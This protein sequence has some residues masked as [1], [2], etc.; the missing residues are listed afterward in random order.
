MT[1]ITTIIVMVLVML[2]GT[3]VSAIFFGYMHARVNRMLEIHEG[4]IEDLNV[5]DEKLHVI[6]EAFALWNYGDRE[7]AIELLR[8]QDILVKDFDSADS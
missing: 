1:N 2:A 3:G 5:M 8:S 7:S 6:H 4:I